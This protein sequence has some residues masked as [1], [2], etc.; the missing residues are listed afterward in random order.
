MIQLLTSAI[1]SLLI[2]T[3]ALAKEV[4]AAEE[5][6]VSSHFD[7]QDKKVK[8]LS[9]ADLRKRFELHGNIYITDKDGNFSAIANESR[10]WMFGGEGKIIGNWSFKAPG[11]TEIGLVHEWDISPTGKISYSIKQYDRVTQA[12]PHSAEVTLGKLL[13]EEK[14]ELKDFSAVSWEAFSDNKQKIIVRF[15]PEISN[16]MEFTTIVALPISLENPVLFDNKG[17]LWAQGS[18]TSEGRYLGL[19]THMGQIAISF[20]PFKGAKELG[21]VQGSQITLNLDGEQKVFL[22]STKPILSVEKA[23]KIYGI[24]DKNKKTK[25][26]SSVF[27]FNSQEE[28]IF[29]EQLNK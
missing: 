24:Y 12:K 26:V 20:S 10:M 29:Q 21:F 22:R 8:V 4:V 19:R 15:T 16:E 11:L 1:L 13:R 9:A 18:R 23:T 6:A 7:H 27:S 3:T 28:S 14:K 2:S 5:N 25:Q 17:Q